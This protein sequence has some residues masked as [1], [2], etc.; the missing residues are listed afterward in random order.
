MPRLFRI[1]DIV[2]DRHGRYFTI[3]KLE[4]S[5]LERY[6]LRSHEA[7]N[8]GTA[9]S[10]AFLELQIEDGYLTRLTKKEYR[11]ATK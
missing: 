7:G 8:P 3:E 2:R 9:K 10:A 1:G 4:H 5:F 6:L 11:R